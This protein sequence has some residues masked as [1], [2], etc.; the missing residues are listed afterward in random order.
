MTAD[1]HSQLLDMGVAVGVGMDEVAHL[2]LG[3]A[4]EMGLALQNSP[5]PESRRRYIAICCDSAERLRAIRGLR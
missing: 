5:Y 3:D 4:V 2:E 1:I